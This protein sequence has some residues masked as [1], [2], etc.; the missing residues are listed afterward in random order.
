MRVLLSRFP[1]RE[2]VCGLPRLTSVFY[3]LIIYVRYISQ[4][5]TFYDYDFIFME[6]NFVI[7]KVSYA[8]TFP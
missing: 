5:Y 3:L 2:L 8:Y 1:F 6:T 4:I 7:L